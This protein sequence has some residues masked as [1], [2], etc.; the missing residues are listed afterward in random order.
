MSCFIAINA[1][2][3]NTL[4]FRTL[5][6]ATTRT[7][8]EFYVESQFNLRLGGWVLATA[9]TAHHD[10]A[11]V[12]DSRIRK[13]L[14]VLLRALRPTLHQVCSLRSWTEEIADDKFAVK[15]ALKIHD[16]PG[17][18]GLFGLKGSSSN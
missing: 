16:R 17:L 9:G 4:N 11:I 6:S 14:Q 12:W 15:F 5:F 10:A 7:M 3:G 2:D 8:T 13:A 18:G 1:S